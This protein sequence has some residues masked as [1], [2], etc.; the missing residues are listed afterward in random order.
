MG[1]ALDSY[2]QL[3]PNYSRH[4]PPRY[5]TDQ[6]EEEVGDALDHVLRNGLV[7]RRELYIC[8]KVW[9][10]PPAVVW[11]TS[12]FGS[13]NVLSNIEC[14]RSCLRLLHLLRLPLHLLPMPLLLPPSSCHA[15]ATTQTAH[16]LS[17]GTPT[18]RR[19]ACGRRASNHSRQGRA[20]WV[21]GG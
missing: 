1:G 17:A 3:Q 12:R 6:N 5:A 11:V 19:H 4:L 8:S 16:R 10:V 15:Q 9:W 7:P 14:L 20:H 21:L 13:P 2:V 18:T